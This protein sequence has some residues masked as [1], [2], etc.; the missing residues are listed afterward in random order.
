MDS[1]VLRDIHPSAIL[2]NGVSA[3]KQTPVVDLGSLGHA[4]AGHVGGDLS[5]RNFLA[6]RLE[7]V[8][9]QIVESVCLSKD[10]KHCV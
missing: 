1:S 9:P 8:L 5:F 2:G 4:H 10:Q 7:M 6:S 3:A